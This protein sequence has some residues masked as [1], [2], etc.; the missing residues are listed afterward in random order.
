MGSAMSNYTAVVADTL[1]GGSSRKLIAG[2]WYVAI[3][4]FH[5]PHPCRDESKSRTLDDGALGCSKTA[6]SIDTVFAILVPHPFL[7]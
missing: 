2:W 4:S 6:I 3:V 5:R 7:F 1:C